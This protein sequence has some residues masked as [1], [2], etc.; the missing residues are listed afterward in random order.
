MRTL[1]KVLII[2][3]G[4]VGLAAIGIIGWQYREEK[5]AIQHREALMKDFIRVTDDFTTPAIYVHKDLAQRTD[6]LGQFAASGWG[7][8]TTKA[9]TYSFNVTLNIDGQIFEHAHT[10]PGFDYAV[11]KLSSMSKEEREEC[12]IKCRIRI[13]ESFNAGD[14]TADYDHKG[15]E[16]EAVI[17]T[18]ELADAIS[19]LR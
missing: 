1:F 2:A 14:Y 18:F 3:I 16:K 8:I 6:H 4:A 7:R 17:R 5:Q 19:R 13:K 9:S 12:Q 11:R 15:D 10:T